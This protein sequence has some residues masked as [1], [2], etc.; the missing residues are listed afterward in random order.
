MQN[1]RSV[2]R[3]NRLQDEGRET[4]LEHSTAEEQVAMVWQL[5]K[6]AWEYK[7]QPLDDLHFAEVLS[8]ADANRYQLKDRCTLD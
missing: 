2:T 5:T 1:D 3:K 6:N 4:G 8:E 7:G